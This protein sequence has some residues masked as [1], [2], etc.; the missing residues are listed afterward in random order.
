MEIEYLLKLAAEYK[1]LN[2]GIS[3]YEMGVDHPKYFMHFSDDKLGKKTLGINT[4]YSYGTP[5]G[6]YGYP[7]TRDFGQLKAKQAFA[8]DRFYVFIF[9]IN[10]NILYCQD[11][12]ESNYERDTKLLGKIYDIDD[13]TFDY[14]EDNVKGGRAIDAL[15]NLTKILAHDNVLIW[16]KILRE[17]GYDAIY[18][19]GSGIIHE[20][21]PYQIIVLNP[22][23][24]VHEETLSNDIKSFVVGDNA[25]DEDKILN[26]ILNKKTSYFIEGYDRVNYIKEERLRVIYDEAKLDFKLG[27]INPFSTEGQKE[28]AKNFTE[29]LFLHLFSFSH[30]KDIFRV[31]GID[32]DRFKG[33]FEEGLLSYLS[34]KGGEINEL[35]FTY[36]ERF[37]KSVIDQLYCKCIKLKPSKF[38]ELT[39]LLYSLYEDYRKIIVRKNSGR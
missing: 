6:I 11:Y 29:G 35:G 4:G 23:V 17:L 1:R 9:S 30:I 28:F 5:I 39:N 20:N 10:G 27:M 36:N 16:G 24:I 33:F 26:H 32:R 34:S 38:D 12:T 3:K 2:E 22:R 21:E 19:N 14:A 37:Y 8:L 7:V 25:V 31:G 18:D 13:E 15:W